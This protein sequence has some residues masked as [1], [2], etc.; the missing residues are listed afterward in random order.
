MSSVYGVDTSYSAEKDLHSN[1][2]LTRGQEYEFLTGYSEDP[3]SERPMRLWEDWM[4]WVLFNQV[5]PTAREAKQSME[6]A[7]SKQDA[8]LAPNS[9]RKNSA[10]TIYDVIASD[11]SL[12]KFKQLIDYVGYGKVW[13]DQITIFAP[14]NDRFDEI[15]YYPL[16]MAYKP[17]AALQV[18]RYHLL[19]FVVKPWQMQDRKLKLRTDLDHQPLISDWTN[20]Q[21][22]LMNQLTTSYIP[23]APGSFTNG[24][25]GADPVAARTDNWFPKRTDE[26][27][28]LEMVECD[29]GWLFKIDR[30]V[31]W[32][33]LL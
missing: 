21:R 8:T 12:S 10:K 26:V 13:S 28:I 20:G 15:M 25:V 24:P 4:A 17:V 11:P 6:N 19:P 7:I 1:L 27:K 30:P 9:T 33:D 23:P 32:S 22:I 18:L 29:N 3:T 31:L 5:K 14:T 16:Q 2:N